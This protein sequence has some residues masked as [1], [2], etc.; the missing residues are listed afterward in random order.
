MNH[1]AGLQE[2]DNGSVCDVNSGRYWEEKTTQEYTHMHFATLNELST[3]LLHV[4]DRWGPGTYA[5]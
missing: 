3:G 1:L 4:Q 5:Y 2:A